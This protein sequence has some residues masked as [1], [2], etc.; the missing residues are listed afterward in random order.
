MDLLTILAT[1][2]ILAAIISAISII[3]QVILNKKLRTPA[4]KTTEFETILT[5]FKE[6]IK[7]SQED[8]AA[9]EQTIKDLRDYVG[10]LE[11][12]SRESFQLRVKLEERI[13]DL[14]RRI[15]HK[16]A[17]IKFLEEELARYVAKALG[18]PNVDTSTVAIPEQGEEK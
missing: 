14:E 10:Q 13:A 12:E 4:D 6:G 1:G 7:D 9:L 16:D 15:A 5:F 3:T 11:R 17:R 18:D 2:G 8:R